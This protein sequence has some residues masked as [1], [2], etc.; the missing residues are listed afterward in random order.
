MKLCNF[1]RHDPSYPGTGLRA[2]SRK[3]EEVWNMFAN[4]RNRLRE[5]AE[6]IKEGALSTAEPE[7]VGREIDEE[8]DAP[9]GR[10]LFRQHRFRERNAS[11]VR[12]RKALAMQRDGRLVCEA[13]GFVFEKKYGTLGE[14]FIEAHHTVPVSELRPGQRTKVKDIA[15]V[16]ANCHRMLHKSGDS[17][18]V[19]DLQQIV[20][21]RT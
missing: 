18:T 9:E 3:E 2:G 7:V 10:V 12:K 16:C 15:L 8:H 5:V 6:A 21:A 17:L 20:N 11:L 14:G 1:L 19:N 4:D 13:C